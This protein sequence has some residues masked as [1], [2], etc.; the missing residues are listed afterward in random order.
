[1]SELDTDVYFCHA[2]SSWERGSNENFNKLLREYVP[3]GKSLHL[4]TES[5]IDQATQAINRRIREVIG[6]RSSK[7]YFEQCIL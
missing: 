7:E 5:D 3:K 2:Y 6:L 1:M 4:F